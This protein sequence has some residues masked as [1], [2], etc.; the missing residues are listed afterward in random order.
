MK[1]KKI[2]ALLLAA[3]MTAAALAGCASKNYSDS[4]SNEIGAA[5]AD[6]IYDN[7][8]TVSPTVTDRKLIR[9]VSMDVQ[10]RELETLMDSINEKIAQLGGYVEHSRI[11]IGSGNGEARF[12]T[13]TVR[14]PAE[15]LD[16]FTQHVTSVSNVTA[17]TESAEDITLS[18]TATQSRQ[19][20]LLAEETRLLALID[21]AANLT[22]LL[23]LEKRLTEVRTELEKIT[24]Q[25]KVYDN[26][27]DYATVTLSIDEVREYT[28][29]EE[30]GFWERLGTGFVNSLQGAG[31]L[32][33]EIVIFIACAIPY[34]LFP[35]A[36]LVIVL[37]ILKMNKR[38]KIRRQQ[39]KKE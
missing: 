33:L 23:Q 20:A 28:Q 13:L 36:V 10:T 3:L 18:Y 12:S 8:S 7:S 6:D 1:A 34:L 35:A 2:L 5:P 26:L 32:L 22:E 30:P 38:R 17:T 25:L 16:T 9:R 11:N 39:E 24:S 37:L 29:K 27:V 14:I 4:Y 19:K 21:K 31:K 15:K